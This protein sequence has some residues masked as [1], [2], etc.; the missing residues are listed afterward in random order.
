[1]EQREARDLKDIGKRTAVLLLLIGLF[2]ACFAGNGSVV[3]AGVK[4]NIGVSP[5]LRSLEYYKKGNTYNAKLTWYS[6]KGRV[7]KVYRKNRGRYKVIA[8]R[9]AKGSTTYYVN[10]NIGPDK[11]YTYTVRQVRPKTFKKYD[12]T[13]LTL[14][15][16]ADFDVDFMNS[17][18]VIKWP[19]VAG[20]KYYYVYRT[21]EKDSVRKRIATVKKSRSYTDRYTNSYSALKDILHMHTFVDPAV[22]DFSYNVRPF[23]SA[24]VGLTKKTSKGLMMTDGIFELVP[25]VITDFDGQT[26]R[27]GTVPNADRY[28]ILTAEEPGEWTKIKTVR[29]VKG[30]VTMETEVPDA[31]EGAY[32]AV[33]A[34]GTINGR[35]VE[36]GIEEGFTLKN[37]SHSD[38]DILFIGDSL[39]YG[40]LYKSP[41]DRHIFSYPNR[42]HQLTGAEY[43]SPSIPGATYHYQKKQNDKN[44][45][46][47]R[48][49]TDVVER[50]A[51]GKTPASAKKLGFTENSRGEENTVIADYDIVVLAGGTNDYID[52]TEMGSCSS[53]DKETFLGSVNSIME[54]ID[55]ASRQRIGEGKEPIR[56]VFVDLFY[57]ERATDLKVR[58]NRDV[59]ENRRGYTLADYQQALDE[60][61]AK[62]AADD[63][64]SLYKYETRSADIVNHDNI[65]YTTADNT[66]CT[67]YVY[68]L[69]GND[70]ARFLEENVF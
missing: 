56:V 36:S 12:K 11:R 49:V 60:I 57:S 40:A 4:S 42:I 48:I 15:G 41:E 22:R 50:M 64:L 35:T 47:Y 33:R 52:D 24:R 20:A 8:I 43:Y 53:D 21:R 38:K 61:Y 26:L 70:I 7:Y 59:T 39:T 27:W 2:S 16:R 6:K 23:Y 31:E 46:R 18:S 51:N 10:K 25:P 3:H 9:K 67:K 58:T 30:A 32:Y 45:Y 34:L 54:M 28:I 13:G 62:W 1:M 14:L 37:A 5:K 44:Q 69:Y 66:H 65:A 63:A 68:A 29:S 17:G 19:K 55:S